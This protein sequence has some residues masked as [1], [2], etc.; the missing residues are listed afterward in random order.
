MER[1]KKALFLL[2]IP[3][4][5]I[6]T[7][8]LKTKHKKDI[9]VTKKA[10]ESAMIENKV[11]ENQEEMVEEKTEIVVDVKGQIANPGVYSLKEGS[12]VMDAIQMAGGLLEEANTALINLSKKLEDEMVIII[13]SNQEID[14]LRKEEK[15]VYKIVEVEKECPDLMNKACITEK[16][17]EIS[18]KE[19]K[20][21]NLNTA[22]LEELTSLSGIG[23]AKAEKII[24]YRDSF[25]FENIEQL[26]EVSGIGEALFEKIKEDIMV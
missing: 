14:S 25:P 12:R 8:L 22:T 15:I 19:K 3:I 13:Y 23:E 11:E 6:F 17:E 10:E 9:V 16:K 5:V 1:K 24:E 26:K 4:F 2:A 20:R 7:F 18:D 21:V